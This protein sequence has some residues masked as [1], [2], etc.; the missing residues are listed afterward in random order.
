[1]AA[2][3]ARAQSIANRLS[4]AS[5]AAMQRSVAMVSKVK[6]SPN[7]IKELQMVNYGALKC[8]ESNL[9]N[10][11][12]EMRLLKGASDLALALC[13]GGLGDAD[14]RRAAMDGRQSLAQIEARCGMAGPFTLLDEE[15][16]ALYV[17][18]RMHDAQ[19]TNDDMTQSILLQ[20]MDAAVDR[21]QAIVRRAEALGTEALAA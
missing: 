5:P 2:A 1:M 10:G 18:L 20:A 6:L 4:Q 16:D 9:T 11:E 7:T 19:L 21:M 3:A 15:R 8:L 13:V 12:D 17:M 14:D